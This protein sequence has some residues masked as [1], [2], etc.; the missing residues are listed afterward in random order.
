MVLISL[1][2][3]ITGMA[4]I[5]LCLT[6][7]SV[8]GDFS[9][10]F[11]GHDSLFTLIQWL[12]LRVEGNI[13]T[14]YQE[15]TLLLCSMVAGVIAF[16]KRGMGRDSRV[17][18][19]SALSIVFA[20]LSLDE[21]TG[22]HE[23]WNEPLR[24]ALNT[25][26]YFYFPWVIPGIAFVVV[27]DLAFLGFL[28]ALPAKTRRLFIVAGAVYVGGAL[29]MEM[30]QGHHYSLY[31]PDLGYALIWTV[32]EILEMTGVMVYFYA[33]ASYLI[34]LLK[35]VHVHFD[36]EEGTVRY[37]LERT[38]VAVPVFTRHDTPVPAVATGVSSEPSRGLEDV[39]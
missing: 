10:Y 8:A 34:S 5:A 39:A 30:L 14:W 18:Q 35:Q 25:G 20:C 1:K 7:A 9:K 33:L 23:T 16:M 21:A 15:S 17:R 13:P 12:S 26:G 37:T 6:L 27:F 22:I 28:A 24:A 29:G 19:W 32:G 11:L 38:G 31:G 4:L 3:I 36:D 2:K